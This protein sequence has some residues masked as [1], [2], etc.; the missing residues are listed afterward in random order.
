M[1]RRTGA[2]AVPTPFG[3][4]MWL[5]PGTADQ[6]VY[7]EIFVEREYQVDLLDARFIVDAGA[8]IGCAS[9]FLNQLF[10]QA[11]IIA[12][13]PDAANFELLK[14]NVAHLEAV[15]PVRGALWSHSTRVAIRNPHKATW[16]YR[17][18]ESTDSSAVP[19]Y[20]VRDVMEQFGLSRIDLL[21]MDIE[22]S[23]VEA[24]HDARDWIDGIGVL[25]VETHDRWR[26]GCSAAVEAAID[27]QN[28]LRR[29]A[30]GGLVT[31]LERPPE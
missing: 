12:L 15:V 11:R 22:G 21:K 1:A 29:S 19:S 26:E 10:P 17:V 6:K 25:I 8:H 31:I 4:R 14:R 13:E 30:G 27:G 16:S 7:D 24:L 20:S 18:G 3:G 9:L 28:F 5:R 2:A 23:E